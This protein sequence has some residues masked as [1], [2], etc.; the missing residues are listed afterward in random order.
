MTGER[1]FNLSLRLGLSS[2]SFFSIYL[3]VALEDRRRHKGFLAQVALVLF[4]A[5]MHHLDVD[6]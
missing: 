6:I 3:F 4:V 1:T 5:I 2:S